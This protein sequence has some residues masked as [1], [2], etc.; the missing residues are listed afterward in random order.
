MLTA[1]ELLKIAVKAVL[2][3][4]AALV[5]A[6]AVAGLASA[7]TS[8]VKRTVQFIQAAGAGAQ[9]QQQQASA[10]SLRVMSAS[11]FPA[12]VPE[13]VEVLLQPTASAATDCII[14][15]QMAAAAASSLNDA[16]HNSNNSSSIDS[17]SIQA[18]ASISLLV[19][20][21]ARSLVQLAD[22]MEAAGPEKLF[23]SLCKQPYFGVAWQ[24][25]SPGQGPANQTQ[26]FPLAGK[27]MQ[28]AGEPHQHTVE[29][30]WQ[31]WQLMLLESFQELQHCLC[32]LDLA[33]MDARITD[34]ADRMVAALRG[35]SSS[36]A[37]E[38]AAAAAAQTDPLDG[39]SS[40]TADAGH[41]VTWGYLLR[42]Q[43]TSSR[44]AAATAAFDAKWP[45]FGTRKL[46][47]WGNVTAAVAAATPAE[48]E[49]QLADCLTLCRALIAAAPLPVACSNPSCANLA[50]V[51]EAA[52]ASKKCKD[53]RCRYCSAACQ[54]DDWKQHKHS[55]RSMRAAG[56]MCM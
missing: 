33:P 12:V 18:K 23:K 49:Q 16:T 20:V 34:A 22:A 35:D 17:S 52:A 47:D 30:Q 2:S 27:L 39:G 41:D 42:L 36:A 24:Q 11:C 50:G 46:A 44:W 9:Q 21:L 45:L 10:F 55:C 40:S 19:V 6:A 54:T 43:Q 25:L 51:G 48:V 13:L 3:S 8:W 28:L 7:L 32:T 56:N 38:A 29:L 26:C 1:S 4:E 5:N 31:R 14:R 37:E 15:T 53:C